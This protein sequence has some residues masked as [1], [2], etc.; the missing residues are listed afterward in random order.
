LNRRKPPKEKTVEPESKDQLI[1]EL[2]AKVNARNIRIG[3]LA[4]E[5]SQ[6]LLRLKE[7]EE[8][9]EVASWEM[10][11][12]HWKRAV[13]WMHDYASFKTPHHSATTEGSGK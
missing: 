4:G 8:L 6:L 12:L 10:Q 9:L 7:A 2:L 11:D 1:A 13:N 5:N 3:E